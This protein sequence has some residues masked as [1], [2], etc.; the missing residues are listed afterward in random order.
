MSGPIPSGLGRLSKLVSL[1]LERNFLSGAIPPELDNLSDLEELDLRYNELSGEIPSALG[2]LSNLTDL[3]LIGNSWAGCAPAALRDV[4]INDLGHL[5]LPSCTSQGTSAALDE[6]FRRPLSHDDQDDGAVLESILNEPAKY[7][8]WNKP[9]DTSQGTSATFDEG[10]RRP[11]S[12]DDQDD[13]AVL[14]SILN[15]PA[16]YKGW[17]KLPDWGSNKSIGDWH[18]VTIED[19]DSSSECFGHVTKLVITGRHL[20]GTIPPQLGQLSCLTE[21]EL[22]KTTHLCRRGWWISRC[23]LTGDIPSALDNLRLTKVDLSNNRLQGGIKWVWPMPQTGSVTPVTL[24]FGGNP[25]EGEDKALAE[26]AG[27]ATAIGIDK[28]QGKVDAHILA[29]AER[30]AIVV[31]RTEGGERIARVFFRKVPVAGQFYE[32]YEWV[33]FALGDGELP[34]Q[35]YIDLAKGVYGVAEDILVA[36]DPFAV[37]GLLSGFVEDRKNSALNLCLL[38]KGAYNGSPQQVANAEKECRQE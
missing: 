38:E 34:V 30:R 15:E 23:G 33:D 14:E 36:A 17:N 27:A 24:F 12:H 4:P 6:G 8:G 22:S 11:L 29:G 19:E 32:A 35:D 37:N 2:T 28:L 20:S 13:G 31:A 9:P 3:R 5:Y 10:F 21:L 18:G 26:T 1:S 7:K 25:W 16:K